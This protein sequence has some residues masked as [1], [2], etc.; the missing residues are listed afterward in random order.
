MRVADVKSLIPNCQ[1]CLCQITKPAFVVF[2][3]ADVRS[4]EK[5]EPLIKNLKV[6]DLGYI[7][8]PCLRQQ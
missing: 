2:A 5:L 8:N 6:V 4:L 1:R 3:V 7:S